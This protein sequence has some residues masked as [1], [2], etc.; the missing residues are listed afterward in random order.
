MKIACLRVSGGNLG[1]TVVSH[2]WLSWFVS[3][4]VFLGVM[5]DMSTYS[6]WTLCMFLNKLMSGGTA[7]I[8]IVTTTG[9]R[10]RVGRSDAGLK[11]NTPAPCTLGL[12][13]AFVF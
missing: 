6:Q 8:G 9:N 5:V 12:Y 13:V 10:T 7:L 4:P 3:Y 2:S 1:S 11:K